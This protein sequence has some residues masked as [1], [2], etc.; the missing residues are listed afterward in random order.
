[1][2]TT[3]TRSKF[4]SEQL[5]ERTIHRRAVEAVIWGMPAVN[6]DL[7]LQGFIQAGGGP[8][9]VP[10]WSRLGNTGHVP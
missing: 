1:V 5:A 3:A 2:T 8:N 7:L 6:F 4:T 10:Y 9:Q